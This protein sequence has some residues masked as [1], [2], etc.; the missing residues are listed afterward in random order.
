M[1]VAEQLQIK[2]RSLPPPIAREVL[3][4]IDYLE[5]RR[6]LQAIPDEMDLMTAQGD[7]MRHVWDNPEDEV[8]NNV[9]TR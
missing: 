7:A 6:G 8:W 3:N 1:N 9:P 4:F 5:Y 2:V